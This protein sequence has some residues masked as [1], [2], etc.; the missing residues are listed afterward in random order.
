M[1]FDRF[2]NLLQMNYTRLLWS[3]DFGC[4]RTQGDVTAVLLLSGLFCCLPLVFY[5][6][7][8]IYGNQHRTKILK[9]KCFK[10]NIYFHSTSY[11][12]SLESIHLFFKG[13]KKK[14]VHVPCL[15]FLKFM[16]FH[17][18]GVHTIL[19]SPPPPHRIRYHF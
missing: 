15:Q 3:R 1:G 14:I 5:I 17:Y 2:V 19:H 18:V 13:V 4:T 8:K 11:F 9:R 16:R 10:F 12:M 6:G 7:N